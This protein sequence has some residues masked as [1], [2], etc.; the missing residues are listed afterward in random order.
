MNCNRIKVL[1]VQEHF[2][3]YRAPLLCRLSE[4]PD[5]D[6][7]VIHGTNS[8]VNR[9]EVGLHTAEAPMPFRVT[10]KPIPAVTLRDRQLLWFGSAVRLVRQEA[11]DV[12]I[13]DYFCRFLSIWPMQSIQ[14]R[15][16]RAF[17]L[18]GIGFHLHP[19]WLTDKVRLSLVNRS[20]AVILYGPKERDRYRDLGV[21]ENK[22][23]LARNT[24]DIDGVDAGIAAS[25][26]ERQ[27]EIR[28]QLVALD[29]PVLLHSGRL[30][31]VK[32][33]DLLLKAVH[34]LI[35]RWPG[36]KVVLIGEGPERESLAELAK[37]LG[38]DEAVHFTGSVT[39][40]IE[41][42]P[43]I[44]A[45]DLIVA[46]SQIGLQAPMALAYGKPLVVSNDRSASESGPEYEAFVP[47][48]TGLS[49][50]HLDLND[51]VRAIDELLCD[52]ARRE[53]MGRY[54]FRHVREEMA[55]N[56]QIE[57]FLTAIRSVHARCASRS[58]ASP[59]A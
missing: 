42:A 9:G 55:T 38:I 31:A 23:F 49:Y 19:T 18:W 46:P 14:R 17:I 5:I 22:L 36:L 34:I 15:Q 59:E 45:S 35:K 1:L 13:H 39:N 28:K 30:A 10:K 51:L 37:K 7:T 47:G 20:D 29:G 41:L 33:L 57:G 16:R 44:L 52:P 54:G 48:K 3:F 40:P 8:P 32:R 53:E 58:C 11:F 43:Y 25:T 6:L 4:Q 21:P 27:L 2:R 26:Q 56:G 12:V 50:R 24:V